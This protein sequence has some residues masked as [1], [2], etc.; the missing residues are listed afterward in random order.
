MK[1]N[2]EVQE[3]TSGKGD[4]CMSCHTS[5]VNEKGAVKFNCPGCGKYQ[6]IRCLNCRKIVTKY[7]CPLCG[8]EGPN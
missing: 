1:A 6:I 3:I 5:V 2:E 7:K 8:F 4:K